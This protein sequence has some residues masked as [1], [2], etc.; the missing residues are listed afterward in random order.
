MKKLSMGRFICS[1]V[2]LVMEKCRG[3]VTL[4]LWYKQGKGGGVVTLECGDALVL[5]HQV[6]HD[7]LQ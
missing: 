5:L 6:T 2:E 3:F 4:D 1:R 7:L